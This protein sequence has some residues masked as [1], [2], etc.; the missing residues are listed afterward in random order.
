MSAPN[1]VKIID[2]NKNH[3]VENTGVMEKFAN[4]SNQ[5]FY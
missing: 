1:F 3:H 4:V 2:F 5:K